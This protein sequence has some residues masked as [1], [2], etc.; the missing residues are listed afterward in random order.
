MTHPNPTPT[1]CFCT[2]ALG[3]NYSNLALTL[4]EDLAQYAPFVKLVVLTDHPAL[5]QSAKNVLTF[6]HHQKTLGCYH[7]KQFVLKQALSLFETCIF[8]DADMRVLAPIPVDLVFQPGITAKIVWTNIAKHCKNEFEIGLMRKVSQKMGMVLE[9]I[10]F[11]HECLFVVVRDQGKELEFLEQWAKISAYLEMWGL[12]RSEGN[13][14]GLAAAKVGLTI[15]RDEL[16]EIQ[17]FK[18]KLPPAASGSV[19]MTERA[20][21][22]QHQKNLE[23]PSR[24][25]G[26]RLI[27][28]LR[29]MIQY[30]YRLL[31][32]RL[33]ALK[34]IEFYYR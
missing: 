31:R 26:T 16:E 14:I 33:R 25:I 17:F 10:S 13:T 18:D 22:I 7:D 20:R 27:G 30:Q 4:A 8:I 32:L 9:Q 34:Q 23:Y 12:C 19:D 15:R 1:Y 5:F 3:H 2:L 28:K 21:L 11:V 6:K 29:R 24:S